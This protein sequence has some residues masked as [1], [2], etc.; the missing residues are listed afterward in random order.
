MY[1]DND[2]VVPTVNRWVFVTPDKR[3][4]LMT[5][6]RHTEPHHK[7]DHMIAYTREHI[8]VFQSVFGIFLEL[9]AAFG[10]QSQ[11][12]SRKELQGKRPTP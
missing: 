12:R 10:T 5:V 9:V 3:I 11:N 2:V 7:V 6:G 1:H 8:I 4:Q